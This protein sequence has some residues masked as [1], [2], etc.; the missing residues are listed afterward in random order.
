MFNC[1]IYIKF[2]YFSLLGSNRIVPIWHNSL[3][4]M[5]GCKGL[6]HIGIEIYIYLNLY[7]GHIYL[8]TFYHYTP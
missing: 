4:W 7:L 3:K 5:P 1:Y 8:K 6:K 2:I